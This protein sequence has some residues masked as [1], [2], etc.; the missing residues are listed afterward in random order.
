MLTFIHVTDWTVP[1]TAAFSIALAFLVVLIYR[2]QRRRVREVRLGC[3]RL[4][5]R[6]NLHC[7]D[8]DPEPDRGEHE[9]ST[10]EENI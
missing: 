5:A 6:A 9:Q 1:A 10:F 3:R 8:P 2:E 4:L 7:A